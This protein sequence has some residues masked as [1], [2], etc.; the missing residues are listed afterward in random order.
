MNAKQGEQA[1]QTQ[2]TDGFQA[3]IFKVIIRSKSCK[4]CDQLMDILLAGC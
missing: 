3:R 4:V 1:S 2:K